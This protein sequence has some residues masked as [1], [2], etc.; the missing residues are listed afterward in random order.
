MKNKYKKNISDTQ[1]KI[2]RDTLKM[3]KTH[4]KE[5]RQFTR[6]WRGRQKKE[7]WQY[8]IFFMI[9]KIC[10]LRISYFVLG[11]IVFFYTIFN[12][13]G[14]NSS[15]IY[16]EKLGKKDNWLKSYFR[17]F[18]HF[19]SYGQV[20]LDRTFITIKSKNP[21]ENEYPEPGL[22][23]SLM[24]QKTGILLIGSH[25]G[26]YE[27]GGALM[28]KFSKEVY[29]M[30][31]KVY[32]EKLGIFLDILHKK[33]AYQVI[34]L[35]DPLVASQKAVEKLQQGSVVGVMGDRDLQR[36]GVQVDFLDGKIRI[37]LGPFYLAS[38]A[39]VPIIFIWCFKNKMKYQIY[40][41]GPF[42]FPVVSNAKERNKEAAELAQI[43]A[44]LLEEMVRKYP[45]QW[46][47]F[48]NIWE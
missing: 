22:F 45:Y 38:F 5:N 25:M 28:Q 19:Y 11:F 33:R 9:L 17:T 26:N 40:V 20:L 29:M 24:K 37:P 4:E 15:K 48:F 3:Q 14:R 12:K 41:K 2:S 42:H 6:K 21:F 31:L 36:K 44:K 8:K 13:Q 1:G 39:N 47:N 32:D 34:D 27:Y 16:F 7:Y 18:L 30:M 43:F 10:G 23:R 35:D 46:F